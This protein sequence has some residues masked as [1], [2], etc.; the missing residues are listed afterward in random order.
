MQL[1][2]F[3]VVG[4]NCNLR[5]ETSYDLPTTVMDTDD[6]TRQVSA[7]S[8]IETILQFVVFY[9]KFMFKAEEVEALSSIYGDDWT[10][11]SDITK[12][13]CIKVKEKKKEILLYVTMPADYPSLSPPKYEISA[14]WMER[15]AKERLHSTLDEVYL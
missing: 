14:P 4:V 7:L 5:L 9:S 13:Y 2:L 12:S 15:K 10:T 11:E 6:I 8:K 1:P 3:Y